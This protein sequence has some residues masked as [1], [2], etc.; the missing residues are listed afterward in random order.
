MSDQGSM[1]ESFV[2]F[3]AMRISDIREEET[4]WTRH[5]VEAMIINGEVALKEGH[6]LSVERVLATLIT[7]LSKIEQAARYGLTDR[8]KSSIGEADAISSAPEATARGSHSV[9]EDEQASEAF[10]GFLA[11]TQDRVPHEDAPSTR[12]WIERMLMTGETLSESGKELSPQ[13]M[14]ALLIPTLSKIEQT[15]RHGK[16][17]PAS[18]E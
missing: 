10:L 6:E 13:R 1:T 11:R 18:A 12:D 2:E 15:A 4:P 8:Q 5:W 3:L 14:A 9:A 17:R 16:V 7:S